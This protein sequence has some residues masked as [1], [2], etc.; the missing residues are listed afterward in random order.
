M[1]IPHQVGGV[2]SH[3]IGE[4]TYGCVHKPSLTC[5][6]GRLNY[7]NKISKVMKTKEAAIELNEYKN[8]S[9][10]DENKEYY[11]GKPTKCAMDITSHNISS[12]EK[13]KN[14]DNLF[15]DLRKVSLLVMEDGGVTMEE[16]AD[17]M[18]KAKSTPENVRKI[19]LFWMEVHRLFRGLKAFIDNGIVH[20]DLKP[21]NIV[22]NE[23]HARLNFIDFGLMTSKDY[24]IK[25]TAKSDFYLAKYHWSYPFEIRFMNKKKYL[26]FSKKSEKEKQEYYQQVIDEFDKKEDVSSANA[27]RT[28]FHFISKPHISQS[29]HETMITL[30]FEDFYRMLVYELNDKNKYSDFLDKC[31]NTIDIYGT[32]IALFYV[33]SRTLHLLSSPLIESLTDLC[34]FMVTPDLN[35]RYTVDMAINRYELILKQSGLLD[36]YNAHF[37]NHRLV[38]G[39]SIPQGVSQAIQSVKR[40]KLVISKTARELVIRKPNDSPDRLCP[41]GKEYKRITRRCVNKCKDGYVRNENFKCVKNKTVK[42]QP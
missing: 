28:F 15:E 16:F 3:V 7:D 19:E 27:M 9:K 14:A 31:I 20:H 34:Y 10:I 11:L 42:K 36:K 24:I 33:L 25:K 8:I 32:G 13:C 29:E 21:Q 38:E 22:Y 18:E 12:L 6:R 23:D 1:N 40:R 35:K 4:G 37:E 17:K 30:F 5:K 26:E 41:P 2:P 39:Q